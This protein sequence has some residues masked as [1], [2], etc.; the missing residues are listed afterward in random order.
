MHHTA[1]RR[2]HRTPLLNPSVAES[3]T[4]LAGASESAFSQEV[5]LRLVRHLGD[6]T[7]VNSLDH[8]SLEESLTQWVRRTWRDAAQRVRAQQV[9]DR[10]V[11]SWRQEGALGRAA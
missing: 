11:A 1:L 6:R 5:L 9:V 10:V 4:P 7:R 3:V 2:T 8:P